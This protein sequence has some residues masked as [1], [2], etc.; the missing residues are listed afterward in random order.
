MRN[1][2]GALK[3]M[4]ENVIVI[5]SKAFAL[6]IIKMYQFIRRDCQEIIRILMSITKTQWDNYAKY[7]QLRITHYELCI[8]LKGC[9]LHAE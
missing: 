4:R 2:G 8:K 5:K 3:Q 7:A 6:R 9:F 1:Y